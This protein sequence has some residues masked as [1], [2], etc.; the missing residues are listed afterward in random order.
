MALSGASPG[1]R[2]PRSLL[3]DPFHQLP[4]KM[5][6]ALSVIKASGLLDDARSLLTDVMTV[7]SPFSALTSLLILLGRWST[8]L[9]RSFR[10]S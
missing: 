8:G 9:V 6:C 4:R 2:F 1:P 5:S 10:P 3:P 7:L